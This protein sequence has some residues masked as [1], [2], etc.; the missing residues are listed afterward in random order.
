MLALLEL[1]LLL[2]TITPF[3]PPVNVSLHSDT[4]RANL[5]LRDLL[6]L[7]MQTTMLTGRLLLP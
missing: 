1:L 3:R 6:A 7:T 4:G 2:L 5:I